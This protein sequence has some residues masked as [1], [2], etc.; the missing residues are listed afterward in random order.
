MTENSKGKTSWDV[1][2]MINHI[3]LMGAVVQEHHQEIFHELAMD[4]PEEAVR[5]FPE[6]LEGILKAGNGFFSGKMCGGPYPPATIPLFNT[7][8]GIYPSLSKELRGIALRKVMNFLNGQNYSLSQEYVE[9]IHKPWLCGDII[10]DSRFLYWPGY[11]EYSDKLVGK[12]ILGDLNGDVVKQNNEGF[13]LD[14]KSD[15]WFAYTVGRAD[16]SEHLR[17]GF[18]ELCPELIERTK[19]ACATIIAVESAWP[20]AKKKT[21]NNFAQE[22]ETHLAHYA[23]EWHDDLVNKINNRNWVFFRDYHFPEVYDYFESRKG[24]LI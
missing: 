15:F 6:F 13:Y 16:T 11:K 22:A 18:T 12:V 24:N 17:S 21:E 8:G 14:V 7:I 2:K 20:V 19:D 1:N 23:S 3:S 4:N 10:A 5:K 9:G